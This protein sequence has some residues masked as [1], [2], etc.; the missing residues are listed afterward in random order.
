[1]KRV[2]NL[3]FTLLISISFCL[4][5]YSQSQNFKIAKA[6]ETHNNIL[7]VLE[8]NFVDSVNVETLINKGVAAMLSYLDPYTEYFPYEEREDLDML[9]TATYGGV[10]AV[11]KKIDSLGVL[12]NQPYKNSPAVKYGL[13]PG[14]IILEINGLST[15]PLSA[16]ECSKRMRGQAGT[17]VKFLVKKGRGGDVVE[18]NLTRERVHIPDISYH[19]IILDS[20]GYIKMDGFTLNGGDDVRAAVKSLKEE[21]AKKII[22]DLRSNGGGLI[23]E[24]V[25]VLSAFLPRGTLVVSSK[26]RMPHA[27]AKYYTAKE[28]IDTNIPLMVMISSS[29]ASASEIVAGA[30]QDLDRGIIVGSRSYGKGLVQSFS[31]TGYGGKI[32]YTIA[33][34]YTPSGRCIQAIDYSNRNEDGSVG[35]I[36]DSLKKSFK[37]KNGRTVYDGG[38]IAPDYEIKSTPYS[39]PAVSLILS[40][41]ANEYAIKYFNTHNEISDIA[42]FELSDSEYDEFVNFAITKKF[43][44]RN[45]AEV[46]FD[47]MVIEAKRDGLYDN[48]REK[49]EEL[50][51]GVKLSKEQMLRLKKEECKEILEADIIEKFYFTE[52]RVEYLV[53]KDELLLKAVKLFK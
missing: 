1:M 7:R 38:G 21:G 25:D 47:R 45:E 24:A 14:D 52:G 15:L 49:F 4:S 31:D 3:S 50:E 48:N 53:S 42:N 23:N 26:G 43:D 16:N 46:F 28:P 8:G 51:K 22:L 44:M 9:S 39:R 33:K 36:P 34:Y 6:L 13:L 29:S 10:G 11:I 17:D 41:I 27:N 2:V 30:I 19:G 5:A 18:V 40:D 32:K 20:I 37:T 12:I 35:F